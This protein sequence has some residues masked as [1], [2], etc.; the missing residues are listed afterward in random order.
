MA[1]NYLSQFDMLQ[2]RTKLAAELRE[3]FDVMNLNGLQ[4][5][6]AAPR[7]VVF[8]QELYP[9]LWDKAATLLTLLIRNHPFYDGNK[10]IAMLGVREFLRRNG[11][12][13][14]V[15]HE[16]A[17]AFTKGIVLGRNDVDEVKAWLQ[18]H[19]HALQP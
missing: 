9:L 8:G 17:S 11:W 3:Q 15:S 6:L 19:T 7:Q 16:E 5:A 14:V 12:Q 4:S 2:I 13:L 10:R 1:I 18:A